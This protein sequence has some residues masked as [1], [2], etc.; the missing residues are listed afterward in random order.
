MCETIEKKETAKENTV[1]CASCEERIQ[2]EIGEISVSF[3]V[4]WGGG[5]D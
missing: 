2:K 4:L 5:Y 1:V 3:R